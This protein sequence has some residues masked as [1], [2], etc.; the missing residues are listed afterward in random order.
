MTLPLLFAT[1]SVAQVASVSIVSPVQG[2]HFA[3]GPN[4]VRVAR[5]AGVTV[6][7][8]NA[9]DSLG[10]KRTQV[11]SGTTAEE[12][13]Q[14]DWFTPGA[15]KL[16]AIG[17][18]SGGS[19]EAPP[20]TIV[21]DPPVASV[22]LRVAPNQAYFNFPGESLRLIV[23]GLF[24]VSGTPVR[25]S[26]S[27][28]LTYVSANAEMVTV[29]ANG[30]ITA[31]AA[32]RTFVTVG[33]RGVSFVIPV[34]TLSLRR[35]DLNADGAVD[36]TDINR[37]LLDVNKPAAALRDARDLNGDGRIDALDLRVLATLCTRPR[38]AIQ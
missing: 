11:V 6:I 22:A 27:S 16:T 3:M 35:G 30:T 20:V 10:T 8:V 38:C 9:E 7:V 26:G 21:V 4:T 32:G 2:Q 12:S 29:S 37:L 18:T 34:Q 1:G 33:F 24:G 36:Q 15:L 14:F 19:V 5:S 17:K 31:Q 25:L 13:V 28:E 23:D